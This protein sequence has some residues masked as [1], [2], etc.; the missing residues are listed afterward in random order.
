MEGDRKR[1][2]LGNVSSSACLTSVASD[3]LDR[4]NEVLASS[5]YPSIS[6]QYFSE[7]QLMKFLKFTT[8]PDSSPQS[9]RKLAQSEGEEG[10][11]P[12]GEGAEEAEDG[13]H[14]QAL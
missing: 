14:R 7:N 13:C 10:R 11:S 9:R 3:P 12:K 5:G 8:F 2:A 1:N 6:Q 4:P